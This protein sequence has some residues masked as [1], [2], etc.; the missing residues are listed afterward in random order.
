MDYQNQVNLSYYLARFNE[1]LINMEREMLITETTDNITIDFIRCMIPHHQAAIYMCENLLM[2]THYEP[3]INISNNIMTI[4]KNQIK[5]MYSIM[6]ESQY[7]I[8][9]QREIKSYFKKY[10]KIVNTMIN[11]MKNSQKT[12]NINID[13]I[14]EMIPH[15]EG[16][17]KMCENVLK[18]YIDPRLRQLANTILVYQ[19]NSIAMLKQVLNNIKRLT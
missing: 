4:Q 11:N 17:I 5:I 3:L 13:F 6:K 1:I 8:S 2:Y 9:S 16:A 12:Y 7:Y 14:Y 18:Y 19:Q 10:F 15:H